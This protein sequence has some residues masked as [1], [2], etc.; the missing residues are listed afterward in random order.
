MFENHSTRFAWV[1]LFLAFFAA[2]FD[3]G[4]RDVVTDT[5][6]MRATPPAEMLRSGD[7]IIP[8]INGAQYLAK[9]P[10]LYWAIAGVYKVTGV[11]SA[12]T[13]RIPTALSGVLLA[14]LI[15]FLWRTEAGERPAQWAAFAFV[16]A[17]YVLERTRL[18]ELDIPLSLATFLAVIGLRKA[19]LSPTLGRRTMWVLGAGVALGGAI[20][21][22]GP[23]PLLFLAA[24]AVALSIVEGVLPGK[25]LLVGIF[26]TVVA[27]ALAFLFSVVIIPVPVSLL[28]VCAGWVY[29]AGRYGAKRGRVLTVFMG[30]TVVG[31][32]V[33][34]PWALAVLHRI[35]WTNIRSLFEGQVV[36]RTYEASRINAG[37][38][39]F[40]LVGL[41]IIL[42]P[43][44][45]LL[46]WHLSWFE[47][48]RRSSL[49]RFSLL[50]GWISVATFSMIAGKEYKY[51][52]PAVPFLLLVTGYHLSDIN[53]SLRQRWI[54]VWL[55]GLP[56]V[57]PLAATIGAVVITQRE[58]Y[59]ALWI[60][61]WL[62]A[63]AMVL[64]LLYRRGERRLDLA[65]IAFMALMA[66]MIWQLSR[67][68][69]YT[70][71]NSPKD[72]A[73]ACRTLI[74]HGYTVETAKVYPALS[75]YAA[76][77]IPVDQDPEVVR[78]KMAGPAP[79]FFV[80]PNRL[81]K[82]MSSMKD[83][84]EIR[85]RTPPYTGNKLVLIGNRNMADLLEGAQS[86]HRRGAG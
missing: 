7:Y 59:P 33:A 50:M 53:T 56:Y 6:G 23:V 39:V 31:M 12:F 10:L 21:L 38:P 15:Y 3:L 60:S 8:T 82:A 80:A 24:A 76:T 17:P 63:F 1:L 37:S 51:V 13:A 40:Y 84:P 77:K 32:A 74:A 16:T 26:W 78:R 18:A 83:T 79:Y 41:P 42:A 20:L 43:W 69:L 81:I 75:F 46:P 34:A 86:G 36:E 19:C 55:R 57:L 45:L 9:P 28:L 22:K 71:Q 52:L 47:W 14:L 30:V 11:I 48:R 25:A 70:G 2:F 27:W 67:A 44:G 58:P 4:R 49:Y 65:R 5:E 54:E 68:F 35:G 85:L 61:V 66:V 64:V 72:L 62:M 29:A 73:R